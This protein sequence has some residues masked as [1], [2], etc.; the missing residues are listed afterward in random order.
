MWQ[1]AAQE[2]ERG[3]LNRA[4]VRAPRDG[5]TPSVNVYSVMVPIADFDLRM[6]R[7]I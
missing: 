2:M 3:V 4:T 5:S 7:V 1:S 6:S